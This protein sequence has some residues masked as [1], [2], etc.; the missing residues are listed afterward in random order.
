MPSRRD[1]LELAAAAGP[2][3][4]LAACKPAAAPATD[5]RAPAIASPPLAAS[6]PWPSFEKLSKANADA[7]DLIAKVPLRNGD[8]P[9]GLPHVW[10]APGVPAR[11]AR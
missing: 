2:A 5:P 6:S 3:A 4:L 7:R 10:P 1:L 9:D 11:G 8:A